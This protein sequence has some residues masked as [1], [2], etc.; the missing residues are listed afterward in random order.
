MPINNKQVNYDSELLGGKEPLEV[1]GDL[2]IAR[3]C[4]RV[5]MSTPQPDTR[6]RRRFAPVKGFANVQHMPR[7]GKAYT[8]RTDGSMDPVD[9]PER[10]TPSSTTVSL[11]AVSP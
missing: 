10:R 9:E 1:Y 4:C 2:A 6:L 8:L 11:G 5:V 7:V 3:M